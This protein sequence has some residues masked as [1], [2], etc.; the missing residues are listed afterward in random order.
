MTCAIAS[1]GESGANR[2]ILSVAFSLSIFRNL[3]T[4]SL[5]FASVFFVHS[6]DVTSF[7]ASVRQNT[8]VFSEEYL[9]VELCAYIL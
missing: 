5:N 3:S 9:E 4:A 1:F 8:N 6:I 2:P 7:L